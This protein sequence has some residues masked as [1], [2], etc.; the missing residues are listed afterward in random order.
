MYVIKMRFAAKLHRTL[1]SSKFFLNGNEFIEWQ[2]H[3]FFCLNKTK[4]VLSGPMKIQ[5]ILNDRRG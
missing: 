2:W 5:F 4:C 3:D 1:T